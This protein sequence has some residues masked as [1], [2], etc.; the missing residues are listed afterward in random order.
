MGLAANGPYQW[1]PNCVRSLR[2]SLAHRQLLGRRV[3]WLVV[4]LQTSI[5]RDGWPGL[6]HEDSRFLCLGL[7]S[8]VGG[9]IEGARGEGELIWDIP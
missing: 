4:A 7:V 2:N 3:L 9:R 5:L 6:R 1:T 8:R